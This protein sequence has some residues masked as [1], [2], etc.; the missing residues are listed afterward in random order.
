VLSLH[1]PSAQLLQHCSELLLLGAG[2]RLLFQG[3]PSALGPHLEASLG[4]AFRFGAALKV[5]LGSAF[6]FALAAASVDPASDQTLAASEARLAGLQRAWA[7]AAA[8][9]VAQ[10][11]AAA[12][13]AALVEGAAAAA[14]TAPA[15]CGGWWL[16]LRRWRWLLWRAWRLAGASP[17]LLAMRVVAN[18]CTALVFGAIFYQMPRTQVMTCAVVTFALT[19]FAACGCCF[20]KLLTRRG[21]LGH[22]CLS[23]GARYTA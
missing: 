18:L 17:G 23:F 1:Q 12:A 15:G 21:Y 19:L 22:S 4:R 2:G 9:A 16:Y 14:A 8:P 20:L 11:A 6:E 3:C 5:P 10:A 7:D 13:A